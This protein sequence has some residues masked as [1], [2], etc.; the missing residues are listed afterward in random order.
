[1]SFKT[2]LY[3]KKDK[4]AVITLNR[5]EKK[6]AINLE[7][8]RELDQA[9][10]EVGK[11][12]TAKVVVLTGS[13][14]CFCAGGDLIQDKSMM[15]TF[16]TEVN[17]LF[18]RIEE[19]EKPTVAA[20]SGW[21][22]AGGLELALCCDLR[23][24]SETARIGDRHIKVGLV[25]GAG[26]TARLP[27]VVGAA[28]AKE[29]SL[30]GEDIDGQEAYRIGL[31]N[32]V[33]PVER[34]LEGALEMARKMAPFSSFTLKTAKRAIDKGLDMDLHESLHYSDCC[35]EETRRSPAAAEGAR[36]FAEKRAP[37]F[38]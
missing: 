21:C 7:L 2:I 1:M 6:N 35:A 20:I 4:V 32:K 14:D 28:K 10:D 9:L 33:L 5:P 24:A 29:L 15:R 31:V 26:I 36:A 12:A 37:K 8:A 11:D 13:R 18:N 25:G 22:L 38:D 3:E 19:F 16:L 23:V 27:R 34:Y 30:I 17:L